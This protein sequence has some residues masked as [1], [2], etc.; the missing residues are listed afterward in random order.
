MP[1]T[2][3]EAAGG[4]LDITKVSVIEA[5][6]KIS[7]WP[8]IGDDFLFVFGIRES[9]LRYWE[10][11]SFCWDFQ[12]P[13]F[14]FFYSVWN[15]IYMNLNGNAWNLKSN[16]TKIIMHDNIFRMNVCLRW[17]KRA[18]LVLCL[19]VC[20]IVSVED[21]DELVTRNKDEILIQNSSLFT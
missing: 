9:S 14:F 11:I 19:R 4:I 8:F 2:A 5:C 21:I 6:G 10:G 16:N 1:D 20:W 12:P 13:V 15:Y 3:L 7:A 17:K 18:V